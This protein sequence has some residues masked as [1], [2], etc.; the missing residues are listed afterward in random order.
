MDAAE[1]SRVFNLFDRNGDGRISMAEL[2]QSLH[3]MGIHL[4]DSEVA[5]MI[6][7]VD[8]DGD[9]CVDSDE[10]QVLY[11]VIMEERE[12]D[13]GEEED[14]I[15]EAFNVFDKN[16]DGFIS[17]E[18]LRSVLVDL[19]FRR[20][21]GGVCGGGEGEEVEIE[22]DDCR[23]MIM[24]VDV[25]GDGLVN[26]MEFKQMMTQALASVSWWL[27]IGDTE[28]RRRPPLLPARRSLALR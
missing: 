3:N 20:P 23:L 4:P 24:K 6:S 7:R 18:E 22:E 27:D 16:R 5:Q 25:D 11:R 9:G 26:F 1:L 10:F 8:L 17:P 15:K 19:G 28:R 13:G 12:R 14:D 2:T 21:H